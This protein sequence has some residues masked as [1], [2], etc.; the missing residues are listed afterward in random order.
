[1]PRP[2]EKATVRT[3]V[4]RE[5]LEALGPRTFGQIV[6]DFS[7]G[8]HSKNHWIRALAVLVFLPTFSVV[9]MLLAEAIGL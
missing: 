4:R 7:Y 8:V 9:G 1:M 3:L 2:Q 6:H 5:G